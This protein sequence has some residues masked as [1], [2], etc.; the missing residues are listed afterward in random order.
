MKV[1]LTVDLTA[2]NEKGEK[3]IRTQVVGDGAA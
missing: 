3:V 1:V 2:K